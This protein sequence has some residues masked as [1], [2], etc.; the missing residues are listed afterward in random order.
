MYF[1]VYKK[2]EKF[3]RA[4]L[5]SSSPWEEVVARIEGTLVELFENDKLDARGFD[6]YFFSNYRNEKRVKKHEGKARR[7]R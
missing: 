5:P 6:E 3:E 1:I 7:Q 2:D 4:T